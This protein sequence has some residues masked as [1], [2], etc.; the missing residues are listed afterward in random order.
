MQN[1]P[2]FGIMTFHRAINYGAIL[3]AY[4][5]QEAVEKMDC[6]CNI[7]DYR[8][9]YI[10]SKH[11]KSILVDCRNL[12]DIGRFIFYSKYENEKFKKFRKF[13]STHLSLSRAYYC[14]DELRKETFEYDRFIC[15]SDQVWNYRNTNFDKSY[16]LNF[17]D[18]KLKKIHMPQ[19][20]DLII[21][22]RNILKSTEHF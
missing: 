20:L 21:F 16:F 11:K 3:Q 19:V 5:L 2:R 18:N 8:N 14:I 10:E 6:E 12:K 13:A 9:P 4:A 22:H 7:I 1:R 15:G 17:T